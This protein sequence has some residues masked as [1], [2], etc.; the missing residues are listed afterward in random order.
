M[1]RMEEFLCSEY[2]D[3]D[4]IILSNEL[5]FKYEDRRSKQPHQ[6]KWNKIKCANIVVCSIGII[7]LAEK[8]MS[9][10]IIEQIILE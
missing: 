4:L 1:Y 8:K 5:Y 3:K 2:S 7:H 9:R 10:E 6:L